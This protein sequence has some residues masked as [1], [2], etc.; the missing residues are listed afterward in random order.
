MNPPSDFEVVRPNLDHLLSAAGMSLKIAW[1]LTV[2][3]LTLAIVLGTIAGPTAQ[4]EKPSLEASPQV[5]VEKTENHYRVITQLPAEQHTLS[6]ELIDPLGQKHLF[7]TYG[8]KGIIHSST[9][10]NNSMKLG[11][12]MTHGSGE[13]VSIRTPGAYYTVRLYETGNSYVAVEAATKDQT[14]LG[15]IRVSPKGE[16][17]LISD[18]TNP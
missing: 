3:T 1:K 18:A 8:K 7:L 13:V 16:K 2:S 4:P 12:A 17:Q 15:Q 10:N 9:C 11:Y 14:T 6:I 5:R